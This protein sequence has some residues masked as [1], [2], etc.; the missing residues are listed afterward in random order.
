MIHYSDRGSRV[1][2]VK[3]NENGIMP[4]MTVI[5]MQRRSILMAYSSKSSYFINVKI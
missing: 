2:Q 3:L 4:S 1:Y 5:K